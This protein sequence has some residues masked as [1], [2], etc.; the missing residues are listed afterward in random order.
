MAFYI[1]NKILYEIKKKRDA[2]VLVLPTNHNVLRM[3]IEESRDFIIKLINNMMSIPTTYKHMQRPS[4]QQNRIHSQ[5]YI[6]ILQ[7]RESCE[8]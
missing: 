2:V 3:Y 6:T 8:R 5:Q 1:Y 4:T 7:I